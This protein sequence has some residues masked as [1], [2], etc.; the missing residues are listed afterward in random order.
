[1]NLPVKLG[2]EIAQAEQQLRR[3][4]PIPWHDFD[5]AVQRVMQTSPFVR[6]QPLVHLIM[7]AALKQW[8]SGMTC[9]EG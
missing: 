1:M 6:G 5:Q 8:A 9:C 4:F 2:N 7:E 3:S